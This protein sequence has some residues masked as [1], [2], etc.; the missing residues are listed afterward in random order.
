MTRNA[1]A[2]WALMAVSLVGGTIADRVPERAPIVAGGYR[3]IAADFHTHSSTWSDGALTPFGLVLAARRQGLD[4]IA[5]T[6]HNQVSDAKAGRWFSS[7][8]GGPTVLVGQELL[9]VD[10]HIIAIGTERQIALP[11]VSAQLAEVHRQGGIAIA[12]HPMPEF[13]AA[14]DDEGQGQLDGAEICH[15]LV[16]SNPKALPAFEQF[17]ERHALAAIGSSDFHGLGRMGE[18]RTYVFATDNSAAAIIDAVRAKRTVVYAPGGKTYGDPALASLI[19][20][21]TELRDV[22]TSD[23]PV[24]GLD[25][26]SRVSG[27]VGLMWLGAGSG[28]VRPRARLPS[29]RHRSPG[30]GRSRQTGIAPAERRS[31]LAAALHSRAAKGQASGRGVGQAE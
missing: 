5:I 17:R 22:A 12:A 18:C 21:R 2:A 25:W 1:R 27:V 3:V 23:A 24:G 11:T 6:G 13:W 31:G 19:A 7:L 29:S 16:Y 26:V 14:F 30:S 10:H 8:I 4:A 15:P 28:R 20:S 9:G